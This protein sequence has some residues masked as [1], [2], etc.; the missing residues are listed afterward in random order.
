MLENTPEMSLFYKYCYKKFYEKV[1]LQYMNLKLD[2]IEM[3]GEFIGYTIGLLNT[4]L[5]PKIIRLLRI[6]SV[7]SRHQPLK[8]T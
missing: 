5:R 3:P 2:E 8:N 4:W 7:G 1:S 6:H